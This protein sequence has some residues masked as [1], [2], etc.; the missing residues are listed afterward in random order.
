MGTLNVNLPKTPLLDTSR[1][2]Q[3]L[4]NPLV[5]GGGLNLPEFI[6]LVSCSIEYRSDDVT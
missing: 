3:G 2:F 4:W 5:G 1:G 6:K